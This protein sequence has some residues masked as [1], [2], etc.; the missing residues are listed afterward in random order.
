MNNI[1]IN[2]YIAYLFWLQIAIL[3]K[4][5]NVPFYVAAPRTSIDMDIP[6]GHGIIIEE[7]PEKEITHMNEK[8]IAAEGIKCWNPAFDVTPASLITAIITEIGVFKPD[9]LP[10]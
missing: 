3:A 10:E 8:R 9:A 5:H 7:R 2:T 6:N 4:Y 1:I